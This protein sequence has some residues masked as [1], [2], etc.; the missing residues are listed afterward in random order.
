M[1]FLVDYRYW[2]NDCIVF[3]IYFNILEIDAEVQYSLWIILF[4]SEA[5][6]VNH[7]IKFVTTYSGNATFVF[8]ST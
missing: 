1:K 3:N 2:H 4:C 8:R 6:G 7:E 5:E